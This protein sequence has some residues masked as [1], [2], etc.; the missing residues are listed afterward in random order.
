[1]KIDRENFKKWKK[2]GDKSGLFRDYVEAN[3][4]II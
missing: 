1:M 3:F 4:S 2:L